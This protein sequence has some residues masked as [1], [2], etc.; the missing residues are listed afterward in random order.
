LG[1]ATKSL[2]ICGIEWKEGHHHMSKTVRTH[3]NEDCQQD[4]K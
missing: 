3:T 4:Y 2:S 1:H